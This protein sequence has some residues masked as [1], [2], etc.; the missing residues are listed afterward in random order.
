MLVRGT[1][2]IA[3]AQNGRGRLRV[4]AAPAESHEK[5]QLGGRNH[6]SP[7][8][9]SARRG[10]RGMGSRLQTAVSHAKAAASSPVSIRPFGGS[11]GCTGSLLALPAALFKA[12]PAQ[13]CD[14][15]PQK[16]TPMIQW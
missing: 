16:I 6:R 3:A 15:A 11:L 5:K 12:V 8:R 10:R 7:T 13:I 9:G 4:L 1:A 2:L 14:R